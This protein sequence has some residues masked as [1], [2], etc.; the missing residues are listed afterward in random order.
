MS[1]KLSLLSNSP[2][3][4]SSPNS[5]RDCRMFSQLCKTYPSYLMRTVLVMLKHKIPP[6]PQKYRQ[7]AQ[8][9]LNNHQ[10][11]CCTLSQATYTTLDLKKN[12][13]IPRE[14]ILDV[15]FYKLIKIMV[16]DVTMDN[17]FSYY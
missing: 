5:I 9:H 7:M 4:L 15:F 17:T 14:M 1:I 2:S 3:H 8:K 10:Q 11:E 13:S 12:T 6:Y 16:S